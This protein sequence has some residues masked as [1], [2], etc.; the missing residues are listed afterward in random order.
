MTPK[1]TKPYKRRPIVRPEAMSHTTYL[2]LIYRLGL[3]PCGQ[4]TA[5][6]LG[7]SVRQLRRI[8]NQTCPIPAPVALLLSLYA[9]LTQYN[10]GPLDKH[11]KLNTLPAPWTQPD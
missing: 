5:L 2:T 6:F 9:S 10:R 1:L 3:K 11:K 4:K 7:L 8:Y